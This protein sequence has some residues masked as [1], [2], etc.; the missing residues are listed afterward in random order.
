MQRA[1]AVLLADPA[2]DPQRVLADLHAELAAAGPV[3]AL[4]ADT[5]E[6]HG[7]VS[8]L[9]KVCAGHCLSEAR[10]PCLQHSAPTT[11]AGGGLVVRAGPVQGV[12]SGQGAQ[13]ARRAAEPGLLGPAALS[14]PL[15]A[16][17]SGI[18]PAPRAAS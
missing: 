14:K 12:E 11:F 2:A 18:L 13:P 15:G 7:A 6:L 16:Q 3:A 4:S 1:R 5:K 17:G 9:G 10:L 8:K